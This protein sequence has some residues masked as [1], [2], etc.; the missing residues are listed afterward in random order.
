[1]GGTITSSEN[2][3][4]GVIFAFVF[5]Y[6]LLFGILIAT[7]ILQSLSLHTLARRRGIASPWLAWLPY[8][9]Y[10]IIGSLARDYDK[11]NNIQ[12]RWDKTLLTL[13]IVF[14]ASYLIIYFAV[15]FGTIIAMLNMD[16]ATMPEDT[17]VAI[18]L[19]VFSSFIPIMIIATALQI[20]T[21][22]CFFKIFESTV[23]EKALKYFLLSLLVPFAQ[24]ICLFLCRN[25]GYQHPDPMAYIYNPVNKNYTYYRNPAEFSASIEE[26]P[27]STNDAPQQSENIE[28]NNT[29]E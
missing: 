13:S 26:V 8:G 5:I 11:Q 7:Y 16:A 17:A 21:Y 24:P 28:E 2:L 27:D 4:L 9:N 6:L 10:W 12:R 1:M 15:I 20:I 23:P 29:E 14:S 3:A 25:K 22:I 19:I 18:V